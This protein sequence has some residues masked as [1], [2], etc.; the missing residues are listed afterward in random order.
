MASFVSA[1]NLTN[2]SRWKKTKLLGLGGSAST[3]HV[4]FYINKLAGI[5]GKSN[6]NR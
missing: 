1:K 6:I 3:A 5:E 4:S 2:F